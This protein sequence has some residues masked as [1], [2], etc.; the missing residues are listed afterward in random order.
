MGSELRWHAE[1]VRL[2]RMDLE[3]NDAR[4]LAMSGAVSEPPNEERR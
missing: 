3:T 1:I 4:G 2:P